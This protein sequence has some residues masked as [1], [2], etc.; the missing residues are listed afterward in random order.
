MSILTGKH[1]LIIG[2][3]TPRLQELTETLQDQG[4]SVSYSGCGKVNAKDVEK[5]KFDIILLNHLHE[6]EMCSRLLK[7]FKG[8]RT[9][10]AVLIFVL[11]I[12]TEERIQNALMMG[13]AD[14]VTVEETVPAIVRKIKIIFGLKNIKI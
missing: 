3:E 11:V 12:N 10:K 7:E 5:G 2:G 8:T 1:I 4:M 14:Y 9:A 13:A 6:G